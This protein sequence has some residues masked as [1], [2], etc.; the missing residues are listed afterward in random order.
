[1]ETV[2][3]APPYTLDGIFES[4]EA[5]LLKAQS[6][7]GYA[8]LTERGERPKIIVIVDA[9][10]SNPGFLMPW[11]R[12]V[13]SCKGH[14]NVWT[15]VDAAHALGQ[16]V[17]IN[18]NE[19]QPDF[20]VSVGSIFRMPAIEAEQLRVDRTAISGCTRN[21]LVPFFTFRKGKSTTN[22]HASQNSCALA[23]KGTSILSRHRCPH[24]IVTFH[25]EISTRTPHSPNPRIS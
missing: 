2:D 11:E 16:I 9:L 5:V 7:H 10:S 1:M 25:Q 20:W 4:F 12:V 21:E 24:R 19:I 18:L 15:L 8:A 3:I 13:E 14:E 22:T 6:S 23:A 17:G